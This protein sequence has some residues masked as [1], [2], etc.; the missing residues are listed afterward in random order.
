VAERRHWAPGTA[1]SLA[2]VAPPADR[3]GV[4]L[5]LAAVA[6]AGVAASGLSL[7]RRLMRLRAPAPGEAL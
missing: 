6:M 1:A 3:D 2:S 7:H 4:L 5:L